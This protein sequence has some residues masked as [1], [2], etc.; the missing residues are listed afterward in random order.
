MGFKRSFTGNNHDLYLACCLGLILFAAG[1]YPRVP[2]QAPLQ[3]PPVNELAIEVCRHTGVFKEMVDKGA[4]QEA[5]SENNRV[6]ECLD[7]FSEKKSLSTALLKQDVDIYATLLDGIMDQEKQNQDLLQTMDTMAETAKKLQK[8]IKDQEKT[9][10]RLR[11]VE[12][13]NARLKQ[14]IKTY[15]AID[16]GLDKIESKPGENNGKSG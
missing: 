8:R 11:R 14:Q 5:K 4:F 15:K 6:K 12:Q 2:L 7:H 9:M 3:V 13:E 1:C 16:L 10:V